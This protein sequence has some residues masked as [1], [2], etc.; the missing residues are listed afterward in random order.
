MF[1]NAFQ[2]KDENKLSFQL[3]LIQRSL[4]F[5]AN[6]PCMVD[7]VHKLCRKIGNFIFNPIRAGGGAI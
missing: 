6:K 3:L 5:Q 4:Q 2:T 7:T 1:Y